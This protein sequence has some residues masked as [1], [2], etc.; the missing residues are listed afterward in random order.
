MQGEKISKCSAGTLAA[1][2][3][4]EER[5]EKGGGGGIGG[6]REESCPMDSL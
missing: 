6:G 4:G 2:P 5:K 3:G 1:E